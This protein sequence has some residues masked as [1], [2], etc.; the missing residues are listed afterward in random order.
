[1]TRGL[2][3]AYR[4]KIIEADEV[5]ADLLTVAAHIPKGQRKKYGAEIEA[6]LAKYDE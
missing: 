5:K 3:T 4:T 1:M 6:I 2:A